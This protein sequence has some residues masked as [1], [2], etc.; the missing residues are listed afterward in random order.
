MPET[1]KQSAFTLNLFDWVELIILSACLVLFNLY[2]YR[3]AGARR[4]RFHAGDA[5]R[6]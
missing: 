5:A 6:R 1:P 4:R 3:A 2:V